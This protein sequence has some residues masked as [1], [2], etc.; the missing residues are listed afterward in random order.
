M[1][2]PLFAWLD[3]G[4]SG[5]EAVVGVFMFAGDAMKILILPLCFSA[6]RDGLDACMCQ[7]KQPLSSKSCQLDLWR[8][9]SVLAI[10]GKGPAHLPSVASKLCAC[11]PWL[12]NSAIAFRS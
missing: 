2:P 8:R 7:G 9:R 5:A 11:L 4:N 12:E 6:C 1:S 10:H 3:K